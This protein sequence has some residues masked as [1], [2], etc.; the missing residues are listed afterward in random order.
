MRSGERQTFAA[1]GLAAQRAADQAE[2]DDHHRPGRGFRHG[3]D[4][5]TVERRTITAA[6]DESEA[7]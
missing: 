4:R 6:P 2:T 7:S 3:R 5:D 1:R